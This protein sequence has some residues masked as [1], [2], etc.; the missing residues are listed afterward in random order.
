MTSVRLAYGSLHHAGAGLAPA[1]L[2]GVDYLLLDGG[3]V[4]SSGAE[5]AERLLQEAVRLLS[6]HLYLDRSI[7]VLASVGGADTRQA[8]AG[9]ARLLAES[10]NADLAVGVVRGHH[11]TGRLNDLL[12][13]CEMPHAVTGQPLVELRQAIELAIVSFGAEPMLAGLAQD[14]HLLITSYED[15][16]E[17]AVAA[18]ANTLGIGDPQWDSAAR[19]AGAALHEQFPLAL[20]SAPQGAEIASLGG[21]VAVVDADGSASLRNASLLGV[22][23]PTLPTPATP[24]P[25]DDETPLTLRYARGYRLSALIVVPDATER[26]QLESAIASALQGHADLSCTHWSAEECEGLQID[27]TAPNST[28]ARDALRR[29]QQRLA[30]HGPSARMAVAPVMA[31]HYE[32]WPTRLPR[33][34]APWGIETRT[35]EEWLELAE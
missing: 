3:P 33:E 18:V 21:P 25:P 35:A 23:G 32:V 9:V 29:V 16:P 6:P 27:L 20:K 15:V 1:G 11:V 14:A 31:P 19:A 17:M 5:P 30:M 26:L 24:S 28:H 2:E 4:L 7:S 22:A 13:Q 10:G 12:E 8:A 34:L